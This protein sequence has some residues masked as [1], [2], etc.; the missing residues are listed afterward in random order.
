MPLSAEAARDIAL[1]VAGLAAD[2]VRQGWGHVGRTW[3]KEHATDVVT[4]WDA[5]AEELISA[6]LARRAPGIAILGEEL[7]S[8]GSSA[9]RWVVD[10]IDGTVNFAHGFPM[11]GVS[12]GYEVAGDPIAGVVVAPAMHWTFAAARG[13]GATMNGAPIHVSATPTVERS[14]LVTGFPYDR[15]VSP[16]NNFAEWEKMQRRAEAVRRVGAASLDLCMVA[17]GWFDGYW[18]MKLKPWDLSAGACI[19]REAGG[20]VTGLGGG[21]FDSNTGEAVAT[22]GLIHDQ[23]LADLSG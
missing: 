19:V 5:R 2:L 10:P 18:E 22:N 14:M 12:I 1:E 6:E 7:G 17:C 21:A 16:K 9:D 20:R 3:S 23:L 4:E 8:H 11:F 13:L 15:K